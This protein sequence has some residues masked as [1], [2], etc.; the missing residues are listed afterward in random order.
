[1]GYI[2]YIESFKEK[3]INIYWM[4]RMIY[5][6][7]NYFFQVKRCHDSW[8]YLFSWRVTG[9][10]GASV[11]WRG[12]RSPWPEPWPLMRPVL[13]TWRLVTR[14]T[15]EPHLALST[16][17]G[18]PTRAPATGPLEDTDLPHQTTSRTLVFLHYLNICFNSLHMYICRYNYN[19][20]SVNSI[21][22]TCL[23]RNNG[24][25]LNV[26]LLIDLLFAEQKVKK[27]LCTRGAGMW[28]D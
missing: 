24:M 15:T 26:S 19:W 8:F 6:L 3:W 17:A 18:S 22:Y 13:R 11:S 9:G 25:I 20:K 7:F 10:A 23:I 16:G 2:W 4:I 28:L 12:C 27:V 14:V 21:I 1:M 5:Y